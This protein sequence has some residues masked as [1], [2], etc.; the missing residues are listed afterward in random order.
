MSLEKIGTQLF[1]GTVECYKEIVADIREVE[2][3]GMSV[4]NVIPLMDY[5]PDDDLTT[6]RA[7]ILVVAVEARELRGQQTNADPTDR[8]NTG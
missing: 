1:Y 6:L 2:S 7:V 5:S 8:E 4:I 3:E